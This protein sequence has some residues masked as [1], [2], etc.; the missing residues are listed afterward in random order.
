MDKN[1]WKNR[2]LDENY[3]CPICKRGIL[4]LKDINKIETYDSKQ[5]D[6]RCQAEENSLAPVQY[7]YFSTN[8]VCNKCN[9]TVMCS[10][11]YFDSSYFDEKENYPN[12]YERIEPKMFLPSLPIIDIPNS[13]SKEVKNE[14]ENSFVLYWINKS[15]CAN[16]IRRSL[17]YL[18]D[19]ENI[20]R[21]SIN[22]KGEANNIG[23][24]KRL[25]SFPKINTKLLIAVK[26]I[27]NKG[28][29]EDISVDYLL[30]GYEL[31]EYV[32]GNIYGKG[33]EFYGKK[34]EE[35]SEELKK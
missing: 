32:L 4:E 35:I 11:N 28:S 8:L 2:N 7:Y 30:D 19:M 15:A 6:L 3:I 17:E 29:H 33:A 25:E 9:E 18:M 1:K 13:V 14:I 22:K 16:S 31:L 26:W 20:P 24:H 5:E 27:G 21:T 12:Y 23:L 34:A 10:G